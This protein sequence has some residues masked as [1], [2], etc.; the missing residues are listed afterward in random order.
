MNSAIATGLP[1]RSPAG[2]FKINSQITLTLASA[3]AA[4]YM[5]GAGVGNTTP[6]WPNSTG[7]IQITSTGGSAAANVVEIYDLKI[8]TSQA[9]GGNGIKL[10]NGSSVDSPTSVIRDVVIQG[11]D[12]A[13]GPGSHYWT[14][15][16]YNHN[17]SNLICDRV[18]INGKWVNHL[19]G[20]VG[21]LCRSKVTLAQ[22]VTSRASNS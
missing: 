16:L 18:T 6:N 17:W 10:L 22:P 19:S 4:L 1:V 7:G 3:S 5:S 21:P 13:Q 9:G 15:G 11:D 8:T 14:I 12:Y 20:A 2:T